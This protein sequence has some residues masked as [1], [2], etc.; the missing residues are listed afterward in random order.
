M[1]ELNLKPNI[2][3][4]ITEFSVI[5]GERKKIKPIRLEK[6]EIEEIESSNKFSS[7]KK[8]EQEPVTWASLKKEEIR[9][10][11]SNLK[12]MSIRN[13]SIKEVSY[14]FVCFK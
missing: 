7:N 4:E 11:S 9:V 1:K 5:E 14:C 8:E 6:I 10:F 13:M 2:C 3:T 12:K